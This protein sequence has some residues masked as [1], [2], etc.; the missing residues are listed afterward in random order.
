MHLARINLVGVLAIGLGGI[1]RQVG[2]PEQ[3]LG[4]L[5]ANLVS[6]NSDAC[7]EG[8]SRC[9]DAKGPF[10]ALEEAVGHTTG[11][12]PQRSA[13]QQNAESIAPEPGDGVCLSKG[14]LKAGCQHPK[15][16]VSDSVTMEIVHALKTVEIDEQHGERSTAP[17]PSP[18]GI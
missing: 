5:V 4:R 7:L 2:V 12:R 8:E 6:R 11:I 16:T 15:K 3:L 14:L 17:G 10:H 18:N 1:H 13:L 9:P